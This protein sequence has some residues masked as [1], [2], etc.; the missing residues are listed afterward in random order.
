[1]T[2]L[3]DTNVCLAYL[4]EREPKLRK[5]LERLTPRDVKL[6][7]VV[8]AEVF[9]GARNSARVDDNLATV[10]RFFQL[11]ES[12]PFDDAAAEQ[13]GLL[14]AQ[15]RRSGTPIGGNDM[16]IAAIALACDMTLV[17]RNQ[18][19]FLRVAGLRVEAW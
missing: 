16:Q 17:T 11:F 13:Y 12:V 8:K 1:M 5:Q 4:N 3:L 19:E 9:Y 6:C 15:L 18:N 10:A 7:S 2:Y 14:R